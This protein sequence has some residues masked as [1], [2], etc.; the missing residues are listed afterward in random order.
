MEINSDRYF[1]LI[2]GWLDLKGVC[3]VRL[4]GGE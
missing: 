1:G 4:R 2:D 3:F